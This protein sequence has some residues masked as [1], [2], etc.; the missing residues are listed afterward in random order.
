LGADVL[1]FPLDHF[2]VETGRPPTTAFDEWLPMFNRMVDRSASPIIGFAAGNGGRLPSVEQ[3]DALLAKVNKR[4]GFHIRR[5]GKI[6]FVVERHFYEQ[7]DDGIFEIRHEW[8]C[9]HED[10]SVPSS[11]GEG[12]VTGVASIDCTASGLMIMDRKYGEIQ[13]PLAEVLEAF[14]A[15]GLPAANARSSST[16]AGG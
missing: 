7:K 13:H 12:P 9:D 2:T 15:K 11:S 14:S 16:D 8:S 6:E 10:P 3:A 4:L 5:G 1:A